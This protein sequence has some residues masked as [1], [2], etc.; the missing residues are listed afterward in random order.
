MK[1]AHHYVKGEPNE[2]QPASPIVTQ[3]QK[4]SADDS[5][6]PDD[7]D[8]DHPAIERTLRKVIDEAC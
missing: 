4:D 7:R 5:K 8:K 1:R 6:D 3:K 2:H